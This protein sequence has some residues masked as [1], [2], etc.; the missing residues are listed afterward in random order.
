MST[1]MLRQFPCLNRITLS[2]QRTKWPISIAVQM[3]S[4]CSVPVSWITVQI[5][6]G[7]TTCETIEM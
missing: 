3:W 4:G 1:A 6:S 2:A 7:T 5:P